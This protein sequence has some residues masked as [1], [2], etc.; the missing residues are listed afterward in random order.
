MKL[1]ELLGV[2]SFGAL[3]LPLIFLQAQES[4]ENALTAQKDKPAKTDQKGKDKDKP[5]WEKMVEQSKSERISGRRNGVRLRAEVGIRKDKKGDV[6]LLHWLIDYT[7][8]RQPLIILRP[9]LAAVG[10][11]QCSVDFLPID[12]EGFYHTVDIRF[13]PESMEEPVVRFLAQVVANP[14]K[15]EIITIENGKV[16]KGTIEIPLAQIEAKAKKLLPGKFA[17]F[18]PERMLVKLLL[19]PTNRAVDQNYDLWT[20]DLHTEMLPVPLGKF[21]KT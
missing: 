14:A 17:K 9:T 4:A 1:S 19:Y 13:E 12:E 6:V 5:F 15:E 18:P 2:T 20:G 3:F 8:P 21:A 7:G 11:Q 10:Y 16:G